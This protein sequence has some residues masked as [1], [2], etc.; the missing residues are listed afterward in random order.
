MKYELVE[1]IASRLDKTIYAT[2]RVVP[3]IKA[4]G[5]GFIQTG[6]KDT[7]FGFSARHGYLFRGNF[8]NFRVYSY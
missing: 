3:E 4:G 5:H 2:V 7:K 8:K 1:E 6:H